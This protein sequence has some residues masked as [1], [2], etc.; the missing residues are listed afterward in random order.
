MSEYKSVSRSG[1]RRLVYGEM[2]GGLLFIPH[3]IAFELAAIR[4]ALG[5][6]GTWGEFK[7]AIHENRQRELKEVL[8]AHKVRGRDADPLD[9]GFLAGIAWPEFPAAEMYEWLPKS[10]ASLGETSDW[11]DG[12]FV[13]LKPADEAKVLAALQKEGYSCVKCQDLIDRACG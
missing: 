4:G 10:V 5:T 11:L 2:Q 13:T 9:D 7:A 1:A 6:A 8:E 12:T 3:R